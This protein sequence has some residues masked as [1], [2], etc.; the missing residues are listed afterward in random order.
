M[1]HAFRVGDPVIYVVSKTS[2]HPAPRAKRVFPAPAG[3]TYSYQ[4]EKFW[5]VAE[6]MSDGHLILVT[7]RGKQHCVDIDDP[8]LR[9]ASWWER[10][11]YRQRF[12]GLHS[13][14]ELVGTASN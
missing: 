12:P 4:I 2:P 10:W 13:S 7:R 3:E 6:V 5:T 14:D 1:Q 8:R 9:S 11:I